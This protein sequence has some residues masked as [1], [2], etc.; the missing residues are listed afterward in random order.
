M[1]SHV[2]KTSVVMA[3]IKDNN[4][5]IIYRFSLVLNSSNFSKSKNDFITLIKS[6][7]RCKQ[8]EFAPPSINII[9]ANND[10]NFLEK[11]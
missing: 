3:A 9:T 4:K 6:F 1:V 7:R 10:A 5:Q 2:K 8:N 11:H